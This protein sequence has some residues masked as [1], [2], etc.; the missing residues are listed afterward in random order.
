ML[1]L[2]FSHKI[3]PNCNLRDYKTALFRIITYSLFCPL[4]YAAIPFV[5]IAQM[6]EI[7]SSTYG[8]S[9]VSMLFSLFT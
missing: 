4:A 3:T 8:S 2:A 5:G 9:R 7:A 6:F 1:F